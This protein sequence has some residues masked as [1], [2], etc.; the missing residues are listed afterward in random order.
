MS[1]KKLAF[2]GL[3]S[4][5]LTGCLQSVGL[6]DEGR[7]PVADED[8]TD[9][10]DVRNSGGECEYVE[11]EGTC[12]ATDSDGP[13][14]SFTPDDSSSSVPDWADPAR[15]SVE[16]APSDLE[17]FPCS[18]DFIVS[19]Y[20]HANHVHGDAARRPTRCWR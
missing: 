17:S 10:E 1:W 18:C 3:I 7:F 13:Y 20:L 9:V 12:S 16:D 2:L 4:F 14:Y 8:E 19:G 11:I 6:N 5:F 15:V